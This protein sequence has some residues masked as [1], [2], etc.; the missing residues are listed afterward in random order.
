MNDDKR[1]RMLVAITVNVI[2]LVVILAAVIIYQLA[3]IGVT[4][5]KEQQL[6]QDIQEI[7]DK[8]SDDEKTL[9][10]YKSQEGLLDLAYKYGFV[11]GK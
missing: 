2:I 9:E 3:V 6:K 4:S 8:K 11:F 5:K 7:L 1:N 10:Y